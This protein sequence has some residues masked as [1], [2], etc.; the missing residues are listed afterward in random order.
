MYVQLPSLI[1]IGSIITVHDLCSSFESMK[2]A[3]DLTVL[4][5]HCKP[6]GEG[7]A[8]QGVGLW[9]RSKKLILW[10]NFKG[11]GGVCQANLVKN[12][13]PG[14]KYQIK[15]KHIPLIT[16]DINLV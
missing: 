15:D 16:C 2:N 14:A 12:S 3:S 5:N 13:H 1:L 4:H 6:C 8:R 9:P 10:S 11:W 7:G